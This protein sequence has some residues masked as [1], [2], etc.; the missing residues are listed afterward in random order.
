MMQCA[1][2]NL[3]L[4]TAGCSRL[5]L[6]ADAKAPEPWESHAACR[7]CPVGA[8]NSGKSV[9]PLGELVASIR[10]ICPRCD[11]PSDRLI[12]NRLCIGCYNRDREARIGKN[13]KGSVPALC[14][15]LYTQRLALGTGGAGVSIHL[16]PR[17]TSRAESMMTLA[18]TTKEAMCFGAPHT[19]MQPQGWQRE[20]AI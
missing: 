6:S 3:R 8:V 18:R 5:W 17:V 13:A 11:K 15:Q 9:E 20:F 10:H 12:S 16:S 19:T 4:S 7:F 14:K 1:R 2:R